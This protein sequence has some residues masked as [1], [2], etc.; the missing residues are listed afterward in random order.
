[1]D[2]LVRG[3]VLGNGSG[4]RR[5]VR[6]KDGDYVECGLTT[7]TLENSISRKKT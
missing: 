3:V 2:V 6:V 5:Y 4:E 7:E 1:M